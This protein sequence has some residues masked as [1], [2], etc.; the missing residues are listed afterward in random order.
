MYVGRPAPRRERGA[1][2]VESAIV[3][4]VVLLTLL[5]L[6]VGGLGVY[7]YQTVAELAREATRAASVRG[8]QY[9]QDNGLAAGTSSDWSDDIYKNGQARF[10]SQTNLVDVSTFGLDTSRLR[11]TFTWSNDANGNPDNYPYHLDANNNPV[12]NT[13]TVTVAYDWYPEGLF[14]GPIT[15]S[16]TSQMVITN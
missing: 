9:R 14:A 7:R 12:A 1:T 4:S 5:A 11:Y 3:L 16:S 8:G 2:L 10:P 6:V 13:V 15:F